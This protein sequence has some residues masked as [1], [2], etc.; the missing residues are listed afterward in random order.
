VAV[1]V[2]RYNIRMRFQVPQFIEVEDK[3]FGP[4]TLK[5]FIYLLGGAGLS[6][7]IY[8]LIGNIFI[9]AIFIIPVMAFSVVLAFYKINNKPFIGVVEAAWSYY[10]GNKLYIWKK[11]NKPVVAK[12]NPAK[13]AEFYVP[14]LSDSKLKDLTWS[15]DIKQS[16]NPVQSKS[17]KTNI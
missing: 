14:K 15:L 17:G 4:L 13:T 16:Q 7:I 10:M 1:L 12:E 8:T 9:S 5:Q 3:I 6:F 11:V 2:L